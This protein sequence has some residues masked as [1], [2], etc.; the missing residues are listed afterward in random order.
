M[1]KT[2]LAV[3]VGMSAPAFADEVDTQGG[4]VTEIDA[5]VYEL[6]QQ[7]KPP[8]E[9]GPEI[10]ERR[11]ID[12]QVLYELH[13]YEAASII[14]FD[15]VE[16]YQKSTAYP[17]ALFYLADSLYLKRD[18]L[19]SRRYF[20]K[21]VEGGPT[22]QRYAEALQ[23]LIE[24]SLHTGDYSPVDGYISKL[25]EA[26][27]TKKLPQVPYVEGKY[28]YFRRQ[29]DNALNALKAIGP[30]HIY[31][32]HA[33]YFTGACLVQQGADH[34]DEAISA[35]ATILKTP[36]KT[37]SQKRITEL[38]HMALAR[39]YLERGQLTQAQDEYAK[40][41]QKSDQFNDMLY[42]SAWV[43][44][45]GKDY[46]KARRQLDLLLLNAPDTP[47]APE[48]KLLVGS[49]HIR[50][51]EYGPATDTFT[52][53]RDEYDPLHKLLTDEMQKQGDPPAYFRDLI[54]KNLT[55]FD[56]AV[57]LPQDSVRWVKDEPEVQRVSTLVGD[58]GDLRKSLD[59]SDELVKRLEKAL[60][61]PARVNVFPEL[62]SA[63]AKATAFSNALT[64]IKQKLAGRETALLSPVAGPQKAQLDEL[65]KERVALE[66]LLKEIP[67]AEDA[68]RQR[69]AQAKQAFADIDRRASELNTELTGLKA[70]QAASRK[71]Y[72]DEMRKQKKWAPSEMPSPPAL[73]PPPADMPY[74]DRLTRLEGRMKEVRQKLD[75]SKQRMD[76]LK[77]VV[78]KDVVAAKTEIEGTGY[79][80]AV[81]D[82]LLSDVRKEVLDGAT[83]IGIGDGETQKHEQVKAQYEDVLKRQHALGVDVRSRLSGGDHAKVEQIDS[84]LDRIRAVE[85]KIGQFN[86]R[87]DDILDVRLK[88]FTTQIAEEKARMVGYR[89][90]LG[91]YTTESADVGGAVLAENFK[92]VATRFYNIVVRSDVGIIDVAWA[93]KDS[94][95]RESNKLVAERKRE[96]KLLDD[97][98]KEVLKEQQ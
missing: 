74:A 92:A 36:A 60:T 55:K 7:L 61:G 86:Q 28:Y 54:Q 94:A 85:G 70:Q 93:L 49:L 98:F 19:S 3:L 77:D 71:M 26:A 18:Y 80:L 2:L 81:A 1:R 32:F 43:A 90:T 14:L 66:N 82:Q 47:L 22:Q 44:I 88:D 42:E 25:N 65:E 79:D 67:K 96:L 46:T 62:A 39:I 37:D 64:E 6:N 95:T 87:I 20:E 53:T 15:L 69:Q 12:A 76:K 68:L 63:R 35:F 21:I 40:I 4:K 59:E 51:N 89:E 84:I 10:A 5:R 27:I 75:S 50:Q 52:K 78:L 24:L 83:S 38:A 97:E 58:E 31:Y 48:V 41:G 30:D 33:T 91:G 45:K 29:F 72:D 23:R 9:P 56:I 16:K 17:E 13:N 11:L 73:E 57:V 34:Y 8:P